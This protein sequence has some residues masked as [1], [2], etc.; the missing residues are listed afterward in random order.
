MQLL[1]MQDQE[2]IQAFSPHTSRDARSQTA[3]AR[4]VRYGVRSTLIPLVAAT[5]AK[6]CPNL[7][8]LSRIRYVGVCPY[9]VASRSGTRDPEIGGRAGHIDMDDLP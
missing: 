5:R 1:L 6:C 2:M 8:S 9:G 4:G 7:R 3:L